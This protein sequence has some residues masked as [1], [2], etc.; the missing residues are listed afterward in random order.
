MVSTRF[1]LVM[2]L[3][4]GIGVAAGQRV[5]LG[6]PDHPFRATAS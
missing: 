4:P 3:P 2:R 6:V 1:L 5:T